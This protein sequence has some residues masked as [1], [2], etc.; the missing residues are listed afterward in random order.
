MEL[1]PSAHDLYT[2]EEVSI[3]L[4]MTE[5]AIRDLIRSGEL[6][7]ALIGRRYLTS[8]SEIDRY[9]ES[10]TGKLKATS[11]PAVYQKHGNKAVRVE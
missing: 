11:K 6:R 1:Q 10:R 8:R 7:S 4:H 9:L 3:R 2:T 5:G